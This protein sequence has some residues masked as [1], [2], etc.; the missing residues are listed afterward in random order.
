MKT[1]NRFTSPVVWAA[2]LGQVLLVLGLFAP[3]ITDTVKV[4]GF[5]VIEVLTLFGVFNDPTNKTGF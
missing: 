2:V 4:V 1:Q 5:A 3:D